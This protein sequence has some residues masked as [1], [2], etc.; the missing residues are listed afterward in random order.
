MWSPDFMV[1][2]SVKLV[3]GMI[4]KVFLELREILQNKMCLVIT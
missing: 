3:L 1:Q 2:H 4:L